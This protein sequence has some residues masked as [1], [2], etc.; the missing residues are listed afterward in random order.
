MGRQIT[1]GAYWF[2]RGQ[3]DRAGMDLQ[4]TLRD[5][6]EGEVLQKA[7]LRVM[8]RYPFLRFGC[9]KSE[10]GRQF[11]LAEIERPF[12]VVENAGFG[13]QY[14]KPVAQTAMKYASQALK[15]H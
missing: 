13:S 14:A 3:F 10:D 12:S 1:T 15:A 8:K 6:A 11:F 9:E 4:V 7:A 5:K 2:Y